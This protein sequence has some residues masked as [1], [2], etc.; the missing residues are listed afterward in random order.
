[1][2]YDPR[3]GLFLSGGARGRTQSGPGTLPQQAVCHV[4]LLH[5]V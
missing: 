1:M 3:G 2:L 4:P 5:T